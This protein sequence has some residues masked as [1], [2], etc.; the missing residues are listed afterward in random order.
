MDEQFANGRLH[1]RYWSP[2][3]QVCPERRLA[4]IDWAADEP[5]DMFQVHVNGTDLAGG[6]TCRDF[7]TD[8]GSGNYRGSPDE[9]RH[10]VL[11]LVHRA[12][13]IEVAVHTRI[14]AGPFL[15][16]WLAIRNAS[17]RPVA[18]TRVCPLAGMLWHFRYSELEHFGP[19]QETPFEVG[20]THSF[21]YGQEGDFYFEPIV[22]G[23]KQVDGDRRGRSGY[24]RPAFW[25]RNLLNGETFVCELAWGGNYE[26]ALDCR[27]RGSEHYECEVGPYPYVELFFRIG[28]GGHDPALR[29]LLPSET[30]TTPAAHIAL[31]RDS[32]HGIVRA[33]H[34]HVRGTVLPEPVPGAHIEIEANHRGYHQDQECYELIKEN[35]DIAA[36]LG[37]ELYIIDAGWYGDEPN[38]WQANVGD[39]FAGPWLPDGLEPIVA[40]VRERG[41]R[42]ALWVEIEAA[43]SNSRLRR[44]HP[45]WLL[46]RDG[47]PV[48]GGRALDLSNPDVAA[49][50]ESEIA[51]LVERYDLDMFR[52][53]HN[54]QLTPS[55][56][57]EIGG[58]TEDLMWRYYENLYA[59]LD[60]LRAKYPKVVFQNCAG[61]G[62]RLDWGTMQRFHNTEASDY[63]RMPRALKALN[64]LSLSLPPET[65]TRCF[66]TEWGGRVLDGDIDAQLRLM[67]MSRPIFRGIAPSMKSLTP[68]LR[69]RIEHHLDLFRE[70][71]RP[72]LADAVVYHHTPFLPLFRIDP[73]CVLEYAAPDRTRAVA[74]VFR[75]SVAEGEDEFLFKPR[76]LDACRDYD[77]MLDN[78]GDTVRL[79]GIQL[80]RDGL[81]VRL[82][83]A[84]TSELLIFEAR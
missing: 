5:A 44:E 34:E 27:K 20:H 69:G 84:M 60:R 52:I 83:R 32:V 35:I 28:L 80:A 63:L 13:E 49:W 18:L 15:V 22:P 10:S 75:L 57:R 62:G 53:D 81:P 2:I 19:E 8:T 73:W 26:F 21:E 74:A 56:N 38:D 58:F 50:A 9:V 47:E 11:S 72:I 61:G 29:V 65:M 33:T 77:V 78:S 51:R 82:D 42:F 17:D 23:I 25:A 1:T 70:H 37:C 59:L 7:T 16:R 39:W 79:P 36:D 24:G 76:G 55:G 6:Y 66:G 30:V 67:C 3:G 41:M 48:A 40:H 43:G 31:F 46:T 14:D 12:L 64:N 54:H 71:I 4:G 45:D 68:F